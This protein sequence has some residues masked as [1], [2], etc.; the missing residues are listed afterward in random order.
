MTLVQEFAKGAVESTSSHYTIDGVIVADD[1]TAFAIGY[2]AADSTY[3]VIKVY[4]DDAGDF[5][6]QTQAWNFRL[7]AE[8][9]EA[10]SV[11]VIGHKH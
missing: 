2:D 11:S 3:A 7:M 5:Q 8:A 10:A 9:I 4:R 1:D 6:H